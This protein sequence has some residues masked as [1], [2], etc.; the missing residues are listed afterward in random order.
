M[1]IKVRNTCREKDRNS[2]V[3]IQSMMCSGIQRAAAVSL[4]VHRHTHTHTCLTVT[5]APQVTFEERVQGDGTTSV[6]ELL[7]TVFLLALRLRAGAPSLSNR[8]KRPNIYSF[9]KLGFFFLI[10]R[11]YLL[12]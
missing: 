7:L 4:H 11:P 8:Q 10:K 5:V 9:S 3:E 1:L 6:L 12:I 2:A